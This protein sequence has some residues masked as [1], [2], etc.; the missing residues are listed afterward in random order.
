MDKINYDADADRL[1]HVGDLVA[2]GSKNDEVLT[3]MNERHIQGVRGN[4]D[5]PVSYPNIISTFRLTFG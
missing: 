2:K 5:Q 4:H 1:V 3:W